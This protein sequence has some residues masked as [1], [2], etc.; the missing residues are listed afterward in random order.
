MN[1]DRRGGYALLLGSSLVLLTMALHPTGH[2][3]AGT[4]DQIESA[5]RRSYVSHILA[6]LGLA[7]LFLGGLALTNRLR[8]SGRLG[9]PALVAFGFAAIA[10]MCATVFTGFVAP[11][12]VR[13][14]DAATA[15][16]KETWDI[17]L[18]FSGRVNQVFARIHVVATSLAILLWSIDMRKISFARGIALFGILTSPL[19]ILALLSGHVRL[20]V[21][22]LGAIVLV[23]ATWFIATGIALKRCPA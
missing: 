4:M 6:N 12:L 2:D 22:G 23:Q 3:L 9:I 8:A 17:V 16:A 18:H 14:M 11:G 21:H 5:A 13:E 19:V 15:T 20:D 10:A 1:D 7:T